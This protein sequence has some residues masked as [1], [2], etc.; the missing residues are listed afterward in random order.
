MQTIILG[1]SHTVTTTYISGKTLSTTYTLS[2]TFVNM[3]F[4]YGGL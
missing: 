3:W 2:Q 4:G 1:V